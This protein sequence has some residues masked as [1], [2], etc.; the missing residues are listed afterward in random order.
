MLVLR[1]LRVKHDAANDL[2][3]VIENNV[4]VFAPWL[5][6]MAAAGFENKIH[7]EYNG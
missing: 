7:E 2:A 1:R 4:V 3:F 6:V 5:R